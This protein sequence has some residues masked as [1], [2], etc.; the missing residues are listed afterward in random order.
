[1]ANNEEFMSQA[2][3]NVQGMARR[4]PLLMTCLGPDP[5]FITCS[6]D[7]ASGEPSVIAHFS[8]DPVYKYACFDGIGKAPYYKD[9]VLVIDDIYLMGASISPV[10]ASIVRDA[11]NKKWPAGS[12]QDQWLQDSEVIKSALKKCRQLHK[13]AILGFSYGMGHRKCARTLYEQGYLIS[14]EDAKKF[15]FAYWDLMSGV[16]RF[17][18]RLANMSEREGYIIN[19][20][21][22]RIVPESPHKAF[23]AYI[24]SSVSGLLNVYLVKLLAAAPYAQFVTIIHDELLLDIPIIYKEEF[25]LAKERAVK[26]LNE[27]LKWSVDLRFGLVY[28]SDWYTAK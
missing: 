28:G 12:F 15:K 2:R 27:D 4:D 20:F 11:F 23:N 17:S 18:K 13:A 3:L 19:P 22:Y 16:A 14:E 8:H 5:G 25:K 10:G 7:A 21:G 1:M 24:Q 6:S 9:A 26:S